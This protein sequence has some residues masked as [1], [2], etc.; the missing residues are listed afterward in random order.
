MS[1]HQKRVSAMIV[2]YQILLREDIHQEFDEEAF[3]G[4]DNDFQKV[5]HYIQGDKEELIELINDYLVEW[6]FDR[7]GFIEQSILLLSC[8]EAIVLKTPKT[9][10]MNEAIEM[11]KVYGEMD[12]TYKLINATLDK[13]LDI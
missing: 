3:L 8:G 10:L 12:D 2:L 1:R 7:L 9:V 6:Q 5:I 4:L 13:V 11:T